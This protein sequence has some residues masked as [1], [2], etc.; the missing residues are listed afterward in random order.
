MEPLETVGPDL[1]EARSR[2]EAARE[3]IRGVE[4]PRVREALAR[5]ERMLEELKRVEE[6]V[7]G[8]AVG[9]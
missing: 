2:I 4:D 7:A 3:A 9:R 8:Q 5:L 6:K 1:E